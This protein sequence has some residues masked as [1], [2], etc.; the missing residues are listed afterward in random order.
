VKCGRSDDSRTRPPR[1]SHSSSSNVPL[2][3][4]RRSNTQIRGTPSQTLAY[5]SHQRTATSPLRIQQG[6][7]V[8][9]DRTDHIRGRWTIR[10]SQRTKT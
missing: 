1:Y 4:S 8:F 3:L 9:L 5:R 2:R 6:A 7:N 10:R